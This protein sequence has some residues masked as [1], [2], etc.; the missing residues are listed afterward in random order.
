MVK[1]LKASALLVGAGLLLPLLAPTWGYAQS[2]DQPP[3][4]IGISQP[5]S[6]PSGDYMNRQHTV[7]ALLAID[8]INKEGGIG[9]RRVEGIVEDNKGDATVGLAVAHKLIE[10][11]HVDAIFITPTPPTLSTLTIAEPAKV[12]VLSAAQSPKI[13][14]S[15]WGTSAAPAAD[16]VGELFA[17]FAI[18]RKVKTVATLIEDNDALAITFQSFKAALEKAGVTLAAAEFFKP[19]SADFT[20]QLTK[21]RAVKPDL[22]YIHGVSATVYGYVLKQMSQLGFRPPFVI[23]FNQVTDPQV[24]Q[25]A[26][27]LIN[28]VYFLRLPVDEEWNNRVFKP[29]AGFDADSNGA[30]SYDAVHLYLLARRQAG[31]DDPEKIRDAMVNYTGYKGAVGPWGYGGK[32][33]AQLPFEIGEIQADGQISKQPF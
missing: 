21:I 33:V 26:G 10:V 7:P 2:A 20:G 1:S 30:I 8:D 25:I 6:G 27:D 16:Q 32:H 15:P 28:G 19:N 12:L 13:A 24:R 17:R 23:A 14:E 11:D 4:K 5:M 29:R 18:G 22:L 3:I 31:T 9:G